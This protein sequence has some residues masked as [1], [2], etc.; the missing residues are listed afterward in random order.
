MP[1]R[2]PAKSGKRARHRK[3]PSS[4]R[5]G[6]TRAEARRSLGRLPTREERLD[7]IAESPTPVGKRDIVR[8]F[9]VAPAERVAL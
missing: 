4:E 9:K 6:D 1:K 7:F 3:P 8:A 2:V 5:T